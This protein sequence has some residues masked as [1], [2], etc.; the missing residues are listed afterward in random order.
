MS[1]QCQRE[2]TKKLDFH[3]MAAVF[4]VTLFAFIPDVNFRSSPKRVD[5][6]S[7]YGYFLAR[8]EGR[9]ES[10]EDS[11]RYDH[12]TLCETCDVTLVQKV[13]M[14]TRAC[15]PRRA[16]ASIG[17][18]TLDYRSKTI[19]ER[20]KRRR[21]TPRNTPYACNSYRRT[22]RNAR[23]TSPVRVYWPRASATERSYRSRPLCPRRSRLC[24]RFSAKG[25]VRVARPQR[26][27]GPVPAVRSERPLLRKD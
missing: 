18:F 1:Q 26:R 22:C 25:P 21:R 19:N 16:V 8:A 15:V 7:R 12:V 10:V 11:C 20:R 23:D 13:I 14:S 3:R 2:K 4:T 17:L 5:R 6:I 27:N 24:F 9:S